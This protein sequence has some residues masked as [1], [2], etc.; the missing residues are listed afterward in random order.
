MAPASRV[1]RR[2]ASGLR[3][4]RLDEERRREL[5][6]A[7]HG[8]VDLVR[9][10]ELHIGRHRTERRSLLVRQF[11]SAAGIASE[12]NVILTAFPSRER[13][14]FEAAFVEAPDGRRHVPQ[15]GAL[16]VVSN[17]APP[18]FSDQQDVVVPLPGLEPDAIAVVATT[19]TLELDRWP[20]P[21][22]E[23]FPAERPAPIEKLELRV[24]WDDDVAEPAWE[25]S[26][27]ILPC[28]RPAPREVFCTRLRVP[29]VLPDPD[30]PNWL[31]RIETITLAEAHGWDDLSRR[32]AAV[33]DEA[34]RPDPR[35]YRGARE[36][37]RSRTERRV[38]ARA[39]PGARRAGGALCGPPSTAPR[40][41]C[42]GGRGTPSRAATATARTR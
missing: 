39:I 25:S 19:T 33:V 26:G 15:A 6:D 4:S 7:G 24:T 32:G 5:A 31:D 10:V 16:Q 21:W 36:L 37:A 14:A 38:A 1:P 41:S 23:L 27:G 9:R 17:S 13:L 3:I 28:A 11:L 29:P 12:G 30:V 2:D 42:L 18:I 34:A 20:F 22:S 40:R 35:I 8:T